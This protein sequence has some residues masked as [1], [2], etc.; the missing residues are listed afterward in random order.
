MLESFY[1]LR[2]CIKKALIDIRNKDGSLDLPHNE[3]RLLHLVLQSFNK[4]ISLPNSVL[5]CCCRISFFVG[6]FLNIHIIF[7]TLFISEPIDA[8]VIL[9][10]LLSMNGSLSEM[11]CSGHVS[12]SSKQNSSSSYC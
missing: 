11:S 9:F 6:D 2:V 7:C 10:R 5:M 12:L 8:S 4:T 3:K 1:L